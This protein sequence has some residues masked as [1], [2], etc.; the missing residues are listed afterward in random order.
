MGEGRAMHGPFQRKRA[1]NQYKRLWKYMSG[2]GIMRKK[3]RCLL[4][5][6]CLAL[7]GGGLG[8]LADLP[9]GSAP[10]RR[11]DGRFA[12]VTDGDWYRDSVVSLYELGLTDGQSADS[13]GA[14]SSVSLA[15]ALSFAARIHSIYYL[16]S[17]ASAPKP[18]PDRPIHS[19]SSALS[20]FFL[21]SMTPSY[22]D[23][24]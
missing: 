10:A 13:F 11:S 1:E 5:A 21:M 22:F 23:G 4:V 24:Y 18:S 6:L 17:A 20:S 14:G 3:L 2:A 12:D 9:D 7:S 19:A 16:G 15:E 8:A